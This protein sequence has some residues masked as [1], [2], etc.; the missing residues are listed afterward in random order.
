MGVVKKWRA[1]TERGGKREAL[2]VIKRREG[3]G[4][5]DGAWHMPR[6]AGVCVYVCVCV[7]VRAWRSSS[8][9]VLGHQCGE[10]E[11][12]EPSGWLQACLTNAAYLGEQPQE[13]LA[14]QRAWFF[15][16]MQ[17]SVHNGKHEHE[18]LNLMVVLAF[19]ETEKKKE[20][21]QK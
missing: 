3:T 2:E 6:F 14:T 21:L 19:E 8:V 15:T 5:G 12:N 10:T 1:D 13:S 7:C 9:S 17:A 20:K 18:S 4:H 11:Q 16:M